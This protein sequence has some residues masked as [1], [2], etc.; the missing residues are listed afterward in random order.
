[1]L[2]NSPQF[3]AIKRRT[4]RGKKMAR[5]LKTVAQFAG[6]NPFTE[7]QVRWWI[8]QR[9]QNGLAKAGAV[10]R[11]GRRV[12]LDADAFERWIDAQNPQSVAA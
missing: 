7:A 6:D 12:Y 8:F 2:S 1:M 5:N 10:V 11:I 9:E 3:G 4:Y